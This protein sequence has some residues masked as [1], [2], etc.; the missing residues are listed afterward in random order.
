M[1]YKMTYKNGKNEREHRIIAEKI[2][3]R[4]LLSNEII[5]HIDGDKRNNSLSNL[6]VTTRA[7]HARIHVKN[8]DRS[9]PVIQIS[10]SGTV[11]KTWMSATEAAKSTG[12]YTSNIS[13]CCHGKLKATRGYG[14][15]FAEASND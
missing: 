1:T 5:H 15:R 12:A 6:I 3:G 7:E 11:I 9:I 4:E 2:V 8:I 10:K 14:W 13:K